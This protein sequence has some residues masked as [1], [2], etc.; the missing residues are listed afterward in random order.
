MKEVFTVAVVMHKM[1]G[2]PHGHL[3]YDMVTREG[4]LGKVAIT[5]MAWGILQRGVSLVW[6]VALAATRV[7]AVAPIMCVVHK[8]LNSCSDVILSPQIV[9]GD[10]RDTYPAI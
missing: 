2:R 9:A 1:L 8:R 3:R 10:V 7:D 6:N 4:W 5:Y